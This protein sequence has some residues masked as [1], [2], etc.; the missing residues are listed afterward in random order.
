MWPL[1]IP[2]FDP[3]KLINEYECDPSERFY[4]D[5]AL[6]GVAAG[7]ALTM[8][9]N[10]RCRWLYGSLVGFPLVVAGVSMLW[11]YRISL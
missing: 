5:V 4:R 2:E 10:R 9:V 7:R 3:L 11:V 1:D 8:H 6:A